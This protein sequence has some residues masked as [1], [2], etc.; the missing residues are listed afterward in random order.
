[1]DHVKNQLMSIDQA[2]DLIH[3]NPQKHYVYVLH[4]PDTLEPFY[5]GK[6]S[7]NRKRRGTRV[8]THVKWAYK[9]TEHHKYAVIRHYQ[10]KGQEILVS[11]DSFFE[12]DD[13]AS[14]YSREKELVLEIGRED[15][16]T[17]PLS[18]RC[19]GGRGIYN[20]GQETKTKMRNAKLGKPLSD[21]HKKA[22]SKAHMGRVFSAET[23]AKIGE[24]HRGK[25]L[26]VETRLRQSEAAKLNGHKK[27]AARR[28]KYGPSGRPPKVWTEEERARRR[29]LSRQSWEIRRGKYGPSGRPPKG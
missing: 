5:V 20:I 24:S 4:R 19:S 25:T 8:W 10:L 17:G 21:D 13:V 27:W 6:G 16:G 22:L 29:E 1:M 2:L 15:L 7:W 11:V 3:T 28:A 26:S 14:A 12:Y 18:N 9:N 23:R